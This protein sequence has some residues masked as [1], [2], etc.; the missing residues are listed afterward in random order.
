MTF[1]FAFFCKAF[2]SHIK[3]HILLH[4]R[5]HDFILTVTSQ[6]LYVNV[7]SHPKSM[8][9]TLSQNQVG[10]DMLCHLMFYLDYCAHAMLDF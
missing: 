5:N 1:E 6:Y 8:N 4:F 10:K 9:V 2:S 3:H 7:Y